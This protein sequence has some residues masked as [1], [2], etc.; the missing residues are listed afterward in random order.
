[1]KEQALSSLVDGVMAD[2]KPTVVLLVDDEPVLR[3]IAGQGL[4][5]AGFEVAEADC[6]ESALEIIRVRLDVTVLFTDV[7]MPGALIWPSGSTSSGPVS[8]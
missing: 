7:N 2:V 3:M 6:A 4:G 8:S 5:D 1:M